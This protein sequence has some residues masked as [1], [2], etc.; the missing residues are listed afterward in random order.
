MKDLMKK[1]ARVYLIPDYM[2][3]NTI[4]TYSLAN[5]AFLRTYFPE[6]AY[7]LTPNKYLKSKKRKR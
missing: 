1:E 4:T 7:G 6:S 5:E 2:K 3:T